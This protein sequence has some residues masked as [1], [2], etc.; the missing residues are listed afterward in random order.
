LKP[1]GFHPTDEN[2]RFL[3]GDSARYPGAA[4]EFRIT[5]ERKEEAVAN[6]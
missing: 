6:Q 3:V 1:E 4:I 5:C 2:E